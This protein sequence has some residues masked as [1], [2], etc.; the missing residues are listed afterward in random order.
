M[1]NPNQIQIGV[2]NLQLDNN[3]TGTKCEIVLNSLFFIRKLVADM[4][5]CIVMGPTNREQRT[6][7]QV[8]S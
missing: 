1:K 2:C 7:Y 5:K 3:K 8:G 6:M 4:P